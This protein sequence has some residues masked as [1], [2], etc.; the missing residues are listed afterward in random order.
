MLTNRFPCLDVELLNAIANNSPHVIKFL[1]VMTLC[2]TVIPIKR[3]DLHPSDSFTPRLVFILI[4]IYLFLSFVLLLPV[5]ADQFF[6][7]PSPRMRMLL[8]MRQQIYIW[9]LSAKTE[10]MQVG[11]MTPKFGCFVSF[12]MV[13]FAK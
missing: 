12:H 13:V 2:N 9:F 7:K 8:L 3:L 5:L 4:I 10:I 11:F 1:T 6:I